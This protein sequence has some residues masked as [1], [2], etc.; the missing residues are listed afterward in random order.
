MEPPKPAPA[1]K[2]NPFVNL[3][4]NIIIPSTI[5]MKYSKE[6]Y[7]GPV[8]GLI[9]ALL[10]PIVYGIYDLLDRKKVNFF[11][12]LGVV[13]ILLTG[14]IGLMHLDA[15]WIA[16]K[17]AAIPAMI[18]LAVL[19]S[20]RSPFPLV[21]KLIY[22]ESI[23]NIDAV[24]EALHRNNSRNQFEKLLVNSS[25]LLSG[26]FFLSAALNYGLAK[27]ILH[28]SPGSPAFNEELGKMT[29][30]SY[31]VIVVPSMI[32]MSLALWMLVHGIKKLTGLSLENIFKVH[33]G[34]AKD[35]GKK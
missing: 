20:I 3:L 33:E 19:L 26:S 25:Y 28:S 1:K 7:L 8:N 18:G 9:V 21:K 5:L 29:A 14:G 32:V 4:L 12:I 24:N 16:I 23:I 15:H 13:S 10:F 22:N 35:T 30:L 17:E 2:E 6:E 31:P 27:Y 34:Q 11:S